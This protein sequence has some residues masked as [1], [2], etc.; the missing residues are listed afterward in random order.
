MP[1][2]TIKGPDGKNYSIEGPAGATRS[3]VI[4]RI[5]QR[6]TSTQ[7]VPSV[8]QNFTAP[9]AGGDVDPRMLELAR[10]MPGTQFDFSEY[11][12]TDTQGGRAQLPTLSPQQETAAASSVSLRPGANR[13]IDAARENNLEQSL[14]DIGGQRVSTQGEIVQD[15]LSRVPR[16]LRTPLTGLAG[17]TM[18]TMALGGQVTDALGVT[19]DAAGV[20]TGIDKDFSEGRRNL[21]TSMLEDSAEG[22]VRSVMDL[23]TF[24]TTGG[25]GVIGGFVSKAVQDAELTGREAGL[26]GPELGNYMMTQGAI[27]GTVTAVFQRLGLGGLERTPAGAAVKQ[28]L[29]GA[30]KQVGIQ[31]LS[32]LGEENIITLA[33]AVADDLAGVNEL[34]AADIPGMIAETSLTTLMTMG[35]AEGGRKVG[36]KAAGLAQQKFAREGTQ[37]PPSPTSPAA[38]PQAA[39]PTQQETA[40]QDVEQATGPKPEVEPQTP[41]TQPPAP[42]TEAAADGPNDVTVAPTEAPAP[43]GQDVPEAP[44]FKREERRDPERA[45]NR[46]EIEDLIRRGETEK[47]I[48]AVESLRTEM[49]TDPLTGLGNKRAL[50]TRAQE[51][52]SDAAATDTPQPFAFIDADNLKV[53]NEAWGHEG[54]DAV[55]REWSDIIQEE[56]GGAAKGYRQ[57]GDEFA[58]IPTGPM[59]EQEMNDLVTRVQERV[60]RKEIVP[61][62]TT[63]LSIGVTSV[64]PG[65]SFSDAYARADDLSTEAKL[66]GKVARGEVTSRA[67]AMSKISET[68]TPPAVEQAQVEDTRSLTEKLADGEGLSGRQEE[69]RAI[70]RELDL[71]TLEDH[72]AQTFESWREQAIEQGIPDRAEAMARDLLDKPRVITPVENAGIVLKLRSLFDQHT[73]LTSLIEKAESDSDIKTLAATRNEI[74]ESIDIITHALDKAAGAEAGRALV[75]RKMAIHKDWTLASLVNEAKARKGSPLTP[76]ERSELESLE[77]KHRKS[78]EDARKQE[79]DTERKNAKDKITKD[80]SKA[81]RKKQPDG[82]KAK[83][84]AE[85]DAELAELDPAD[86]HYLAQVALNRAKHPAHNRS[87]QSI[88]DA[89]KA[90]VPLAPGTNIKTQDVMIED[91]TYGYLLQQGTETKKK[92]VSLLGLFKRDLKLKAKARNEIGQLLDELETGEWTTRRPNGKKTTDSVL[93]MLEEKRSSMR[94]E[95][96]LQKQIAETEA[97]IESGKYDDMK[98]DQGGDA[99]TYLRDRLRDRRQELSLLRDIENLEQQLRTGQFQDPPKSQ[100][101]ASE[102]LAELE[103]RRNILRAKIAEWQAA[104]IPHTPWQRTA[105][106]LGIPRALMASMDVSM[107]GI[108]GAWNALAH[109]VDTARAVPGMLRS[110]VSEV[111]AQQQLDAIMNG[112]HY[113]QFVRQGGEITSW[114]GNLNEREEQFR[115]DLLE[116]VPVLGTALRGSTRA[117]T[118]FL[119]TLRYNSFA[120]LV[121]KDGGVITDERASLYA[122]YVNTATGRGSLGPKGSKLNNASGLLSIMFFSARNW[123][124]KIELVVGAPLIRAAVKGDK[125]ATAVVAKEYARFLGALTLLIGLWELFGGEAELDPRSSGFLRMS[126]TDEDGH[127]YNFDPSGQLGGEVAFWSRLLTGTRVTPAGE[128]QDIRYASWGKGDAFDLV[129]RKVRG[130]LSP[131]ASYTVDTGTGADYLGKPFEPIGATASRMYP[132]AFKDV[133]EA[134]K[135]EN[136][137]SKLALALLALAGNRPW[138]IDNAEMESK[139][140]AWATEKKRRKTIREAG[141]YSPMEEWYP[142]GVGTYIRKNTGF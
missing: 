21:G 88:L 18:S 75:A 31:T 6:M 43:V 112:R 5:Q 29:R 40:V 62:V 30:M 126:W 12:Q 103:A 46:A 78:E 63:G 85:L 26:E 121:E 82:R 142:E 27:E 102:R 20:Y 134:M 80:A 124:S 65:E 93:A 42:E 141:D 101:K 131:V 64:Q 132:L 84:P 94:S 60:G 76:E 10:N 3:E 8:P 83:T 13:L 54:A 38:A 17:S 99:L 66:A 137:E 118:T 139:W 7:T 119:N 97:Q 45:D 51:I 120:A 77:R 61:G 22:A 114:R 127:K 24:A 104:L 69:T 14:R 58:I 41:L 129:A 105:N 73:K 1:V 108:Q 33:S 35:L 37:T 109:P 15:N 122:S 115:S 81:K 113:A 2:Y 52:E 16:A 56:S 28:G 34:N 19:E 111:S 79:K 59:T 130:K 107:I 87:Y 90:V 48:E 11:N 98:T 25:V 57:G 71:R 89:T 70:R 128:V 32:E 91:N 133:A 123:A 9:T 125:R 100:R 116:R 86:P 95:R 74:E 23:L 55:M 4:S 39:A 110:Y 96:D 117:Y 47:A 140:E 50:D 36:S 68:P 53:M 138:R 72:D 49:N 135:A 106:Y 67:E 92:T 136:S 44:T